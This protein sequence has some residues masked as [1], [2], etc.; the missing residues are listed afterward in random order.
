MRGV[1]ECN[2][3]EGWAPLCIANTWLS[4]LVSMM[5]TMPFSAALTGRDGQQR[6]CKSAA[7]QAAV[8]ALMLLGSQEVN[9][10][11]PSWICGR[12][13]D[14]QITL[15]GWFMVQVT[16]GCHLRI[17]TSDLANLSS[18]SSHPCETSS[19]STPPPLQSIRIQLYCFSG[20]QPMAQSSNEPLAGTVGGSSLPWNVIAL[21]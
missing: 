18:V 1:E 11:R 10:F 3:Q 21:P 5:L 20:W 8:H 16:V 15:W 7:C 13:G 2:H 6:P 9:K 19:F 12:Q 17:L 14:M 4:G